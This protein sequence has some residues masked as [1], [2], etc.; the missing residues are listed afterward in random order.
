VDQELWDRARARLDAIYVSASVTK[1]RSTK[2][3]EQR[4]AKHLLTGLVSCGNCD[5]PYAAAGRHYLACS[6]ARR[7]GTCSSSRGIPR[8]ALE[9]VVLEAL[10]RHLLAPEYVQEF[11]SAFH[12]E[13]NR[14]RHDAEILVGV[15]RRELEDVGRRLDGLIDAIADGLRAPGLQSKLDQLESRK[16]ELARELT[17]IPPT[18][19]RFHPRLAELY[20][21]KVARLHVALA[22]ADERDEALEILRGLIE[23]VVVRPSATDR[24]FEIELVGEI[25]N[26][27]A[28]LPGA[29]SAVQDPYRSSVKVVAGEGFEPPTLGL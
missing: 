17:V 5:S 27:V 19:P 28:L 22:E 9:D 7:R 13:L 6:A 21:D 14:Q 26:M 12:T 1:A 11:V 29:E 16:V 3:W 24:S 23:R 8:Q 15:K 10:K 4:K 2:F 25:A 20:Q 18:P